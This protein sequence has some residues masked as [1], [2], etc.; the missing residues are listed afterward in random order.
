MF[1]FFQNQI[2]SVKLLYYYTYFLFF[3]DIILFRTKN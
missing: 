1:S 3:I 2:T